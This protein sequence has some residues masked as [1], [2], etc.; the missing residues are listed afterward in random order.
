[1]FRFTQFFA[2]AAAGLFLAWSTNDAQAQCYP[3]PVYHGHPGFYQVQQ[4]YYS[5]PAYR[6]A[7]SVSFGTTSFQQY[8]R[9]Y[10]AR[11]AYG[12][13]FHPGYGHHHGHHHGHRHGGWG[14]PYGGS[15]ISIRF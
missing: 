3:R 4:T 11:P 14:S 6:P 7:V 5:V 12:P 8:H 10:Q 1:M 13:S 9:H 15:G 2:V